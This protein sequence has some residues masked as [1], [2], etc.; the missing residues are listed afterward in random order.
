MEVT[1]LTKYVRISPKKAREVARVLP[2]RDANEALELLAF[3]PR[4]AA[5]EFRKTLQS[6][7]ANAE[8]NHSLVSDDLVIHKAMVDEGPAM[9]R[10]RPVARGSAHPYKK[11]MSHFR[12]VLT[13]KAEAPAETAN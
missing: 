8:N 4:K 1:A 9:K 5:R 11:R 3:I 10:F 7:I 2:G 6:A 12:I 13:E